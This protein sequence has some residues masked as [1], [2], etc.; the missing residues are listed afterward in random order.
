[1]KS[2]TDKILE[3]I[4][5]LALASLLF[6]GI[7]I[8]IYWPR[9]VESS[10]SVTKE[11]NKLIIEE[12]TKPEQFQKEKPLEEVNLPDSFTLDIPFI[13]QAP[14]GD[15]KPP[16]DHACEEATVLMVHYYLQDKPVDPIKAAQEIRNIVDFEAENY[17][18]YEDTSV[19]ETAQL[20]EDY[21]GYKVKVYY[22]ISLEDIKKE[23]VKGNPV[24]I[25]AAGRLLD[26]PHFTPPGPIYH[27][28]V[29][30]GYNSTEFI[31]NDP[32]TRRGADY[33]YPY[34]TLEKA[35]HDWNNGDIKNGKS[36]M[37]SVSD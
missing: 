16:F 15:W 19:A 13:C 21:Y 36:A 27:M 17:G 6:E 7:Y 25:P 18:F 33:A 3:I 28:L 31:T 1:M 2:K 30:K 10:S 11:E 5:V 32:G 9:P 23:L 29:I 22:G 8:Y 34:R 12:S 37:I 4:T 14:L 20:I 35:I 24:I 26:N